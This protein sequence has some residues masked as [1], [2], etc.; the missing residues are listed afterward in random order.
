LATKVTPV[1]LKLSR[2]VL[3]FPRYGSEKDS[4][5]LTNFFDLLSELIHSLSKS[6]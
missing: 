3:D 4:G 5:L 6:V 2:N 1:L